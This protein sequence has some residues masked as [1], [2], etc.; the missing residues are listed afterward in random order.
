VKTL[1]DYGASRPAT[2]HLG[3]AARSTATTRAE[4]ERTAHTTHVVRRCR[5]TMRRGRSCGAII[6]HTKV[7]TASVVE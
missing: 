2:A 3:D 1:L 6:I 4:E 7:R 5:I